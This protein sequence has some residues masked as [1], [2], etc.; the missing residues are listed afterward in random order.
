[1]CNIYLG[2]FFSILVFLEKSD[3]LICVGSAREA[4]EDGALRFGWN[5]SK[6]R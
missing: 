4:Y 2:A 3:L 6:T 1:M 5:L